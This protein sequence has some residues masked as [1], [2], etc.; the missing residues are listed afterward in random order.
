VRIEAEGFYRRNEPDSDGV[1]GGPLASGEGEVE[2]Y[3]AMFNVFY[4]P[5]YLNW[6]VYPYIGAGVGYAEVETSLAL[7]A[8]TVNDDDS[9]LAYQGI[10]GVRWPVTENVSLT[11]DGRY[12]SMENPE[13]T[14]S[15]GEPFEFEYDSITGVFGLQYRF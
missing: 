11:L 1:V 14:G 3:G 2:A 5:E 4:S 13:F 7:N 9:V 8:F 12:F 15:G 10:L 6:P